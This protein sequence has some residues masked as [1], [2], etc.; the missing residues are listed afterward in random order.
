MKFRSDLVLAVA[1]AVLSSSLSPRAYAQPLAPTDGYRISVLTM[2]PGDQFVSRFGHDALLV[3]R[4]GLPSLVY[5]FGTYTDQAILPHHV[6]G[7]TLLYYLSVDYLA[8]T[9][10]VYRAQNRTVT[11]QV[12]NLDQPT[13]ERLARALSLNSEPANTT[14]H[15][16]FARDNCTTRVRDALDRALGGAL[17]SE[18]GGASHYTYRDHALRFSANT[19]L[20]ALLFDVGL[21]KNADQPLDEWDD[22]FLPD[23]LAHYLAEARIT[24]ATGSHPLVAREATLFAAARE[25]VP[26]RPPPRAPFYGLASAT[27]GVLL[28]RAARRPRLRRLLGFAGA[29]VG[30]FVGGLGTFVLLLLATHVHPA[31][32]ANFNALVCPA[33][34]LLLVPAGLAVTFGSA[35]RLRA[36]ELAAASSLLFATAGT[37]VAAGYGQDSARVAVLVVPLLS[38]VWLAARAATRAA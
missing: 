1:C 3:E 18:L 19:P 23:R 32:H 8:R 7:G 12:L 21:G 16:D 36:L 15:Y 30:V 20:L 2:G 4:G 34:A 14:Y 26:A 28:A 17:R 9:V 24:D 22:A 29:C 31:S 25:A 38:G 10:P 13:A 11:Q 5:N 27:F 33:W 35:K 37:L 6:L